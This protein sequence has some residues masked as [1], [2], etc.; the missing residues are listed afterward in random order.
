LR[1]DKADWARLAR[2]CQGLCRSGSY[3]LTLITQSSKRLLPFQKIRRLVIDGT[4]IATK[5]LADQVIIIMSSGQRILHVIP[6]RVH[7]RRILGAGI[8]QLDGL[9]RARPEREIHPEEM[10]RIAMREVDDHTPTCLSVLARSSHRH[11]LTG[12]RRS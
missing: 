3:I 11:G 5:L 1:L 4:R 10:L 7:N 9:T 2:Y 6:D 12:Y 8:H